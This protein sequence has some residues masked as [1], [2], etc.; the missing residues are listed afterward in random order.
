MAPAKRSFYYYY[1]Y[2]ATGQIHE[3]YPNLI[4]IFA[5]SSTCEQEQQYYI[6]PKRKSL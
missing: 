1:Y 5:I 6:T 4:M 3:S 2:L